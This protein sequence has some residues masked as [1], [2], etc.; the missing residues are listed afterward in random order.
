MFDVIILG[1]GP[2][3]IGAGVYVAR[4]Q[5]KS[6]LVTE[7]F[8]GQSIVSD[9]IQNWI[10]ETH[11]SGIDL[12]KKLE[13]H[14]RGYPETLEVRDGER[15]TLVRKKEKN[16]GGFFVFEV[17]SEKGTYESLSV[18]VATGGRRRTLNISGEKEL[19]G[20]G[21]AYCSTC[22][23]PLFKGKAV[24]VV[25]GG[26]AGLEAVQDLLPYASKI[27]LL[28]FGAAVTGDQ[29]TYQK[30]KNDLRLTVLNNVATKAIHGGNFVTGLSYLD[31]ATNKEQELLVQGVFVEIGS[32]PNSECVKALVTTDAYG[33]II[34]DMKYATTS[35]PGVF[36]AGDVTDDPFKQNN[37]SV[38]DGVRAALSAYDYLLKK[39]RQ[40]PAAE[41]DH[42]GT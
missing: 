31:R 37:I 13:N 2:A 4:K 42:H 41:K 17:V 1:G 18:I 6:L 34:T 8:A 16:V 29:T 26:N 23:A 21:V 36:A 33:Q 20:H 7:S 15:V 11:I 25:G 22:D 35:C 5:L 28:N 24:A 32:V 38:G 3:A 27:Y 9:D 19:N 12:A 10:G 40:S 39:H 30:I 14:L